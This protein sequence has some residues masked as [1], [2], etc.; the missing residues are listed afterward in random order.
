MS[1]GHEPDQEKAIL[2][3][4]AAELERQLA[5]ARSALARTERA[6]GDCQL[7]LCRAE[8]RLHEA[9]GERDAAVSAGWWER[10][11]TLLRFW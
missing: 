11:L 7:D 10:V 8:R 4:L 9:R 1:A 5:E 3:C 2:R 6:L